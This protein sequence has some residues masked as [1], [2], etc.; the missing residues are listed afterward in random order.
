MSRVK[1]PVFNKIEVSKLK[2]LD[3][4]L[5]MH[6]TKITEW[7]GRNRRKEFGR[8]EL[9]PYHAAIVYENI[10]AKGVEEA[11]NVFIV[12]PEI[13]TSLSLL[14]EYTMKSSIRIDVFRYNYNVT[15]SHLVKA[16]MTEAVREERKYDGKGFGFFLSQMP[17]CGW[18]EN[19]LPKPSEKDFFCS[20]AVT[21]FMQS[22]G[23]ITISPRDHNKTAP[24]DIQLYG[25]ENTSECTKYTLKERTQ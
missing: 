20:D 1:I 18:L 25:I 22:R 13:T 21:Y 16:A 10:N 4:L 11:D 2:P 15:Q 7:H 8:S 19:I 3:V 14:S 17:Y 12:D 5:F 23:G 9:P 24:V 6:G